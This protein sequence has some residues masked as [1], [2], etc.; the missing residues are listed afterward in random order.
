M[1][2]GRAQ[3]MKSLKA[4]KEKRGLRD[5]SLILDQQEVCSPERT[6]KQR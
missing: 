3:A 1:V 6:S 2:S 4:K 5:W